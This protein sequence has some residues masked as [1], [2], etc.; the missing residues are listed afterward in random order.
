MNQFFTILSLSLSLF[1]NCIA[2]II[3]VLHLFDAFVNVYRLCIYELRTVVHFFKYFLAN[4]E[5]VNLCRKK[6]QPTIGVSFK[7]KEMALLSHL[8]FQ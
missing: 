8:I 4:L 7:I 1:Y 5:Q 2:F 3:I 6:N